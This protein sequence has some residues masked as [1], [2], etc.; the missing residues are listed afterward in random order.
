MGQ[1]FE[2]IFQQS[3]SLDILVNNAG[4][5]HIGNVETTTEDDM[6]RLYAKL[7]H[8]FKTLLNTN[9]TTAIMAKE[10]G[11]TRQ[12]IEKKLKR[13]MAIATKDYMEDY[14]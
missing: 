4:I 2:G 9:K 13:L 12:A 7:P 14:A 5:A 6:D 11:V 8:A 1:I 10:E 3:G